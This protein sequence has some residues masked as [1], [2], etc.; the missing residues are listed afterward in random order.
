MS[1]SADVL[2]ALGA[3]IDLGP[4]DVARCIDEVGFGFMFA[5]AHHQATRYVIGVRHELGVRTIFNLLGPLTNPAGATRQLVG[6]SDARHLETIAGALVLLGVERALVVAGEDGLDEISAVAPTRIVEVRAGSALRAY[7]VTPSE[8][9]I[10]AAATA[11]GGGT[12]ADNAAVTR[13]ILDGERGPQRDL[14]LLNAGAAVYAAGAAGT[15]AEGV[16]LARDAVD[17]G[18][19]RSPARAL[20]GG[21]AP[22]SIL[23]EILASTREDVERRRREVPLPPAGP[24]R[25]PHAFRDALAAPGIAVIAEHKRRSPSAGPIR[26]G[27]SVAEVARAYERGGAAA[28]SV[29]T[30]ERRFD[31]SLEDLRAARA[32]CALPLL[33][34]DFIV[35]DYQLA[36]A[37]AAGADAVLLIVA[38]LEPAQ[39]RELHEGAAA[40][41]LDA[42]V[43]VHDA[44]ELAVALEAGAGIVG[45][46]N[47]DLRDFSVDIERT[48]ALRAAIPDGV[49][50]VSESGIWDGEHLARLRDAGVDAALIG[51]RLMR[52]DD[53]AAALRALLRGR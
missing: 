13:A 29:L 40:H 2:E 21:D 28:I 52:E 51:E 34:K 27:S 8:L 7:T 15:L 22:V 31:G 39:L 38:A 33:R 49:L 14:A 44:D 6:V 9:G 35:S 32:A 23:A 18:R 5:P 4:D 47:R 10:A 36:E 26:P 25:V 37:D 24:P 50:V 20:G 30:E 43:E 41:G 17:D 16:E 48:F 45:V 46:N 12:P 1:G 42:L 11:P 19:A 53:P 3:R